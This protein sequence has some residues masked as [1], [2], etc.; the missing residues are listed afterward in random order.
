M[1]ELLTKCKILFIFL[2]LTSFSACDKPTYPTGKIEESIL[3]LCKDEYNLDNVKVKI[4]GSTLGVY[5]PVEGLVDP[6]MQLDKKAGEKIEDVALS[7]HRVVTSTDMPLKFYI[8]TARDTKTAGAEFILTGF[9]YDVVRV[10]LFDI[11]RGEY[12]QRILRDFRFNPAIAGER[13]IRELFDALNQDSPLTESLKPIL[14]PIYAIGKKDTQKIEITDIESKELSDH[15][16]LLYVKTVE[17]YEP[18]PGFEAYGVIFPQGFKNE[19]LFLIDMSSASQIKEIVSRYFYSNNEVR[20]RELKDTFEQYKDLGIIGIDGF[21]KKDLDLGWFLSQQIS[22]RVKQLF[23]EDEKLKKNFKVASSEGEIKDQVFQFKFNIT[24]S[25][26][27]AGD[28]RTIFPNIIKMVGT[29]LHLYEFEEYK[30]VELISL[31]NASKKIY[32]SKEKLE[33]FRKNKIK[34]ESLL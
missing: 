29:V 17:A 22:R 9:I 3:K 20:Q 7:I 27:K 30:G 16:S 24:S 34:I 14:Y 11:S 15:E 31:A 4:V 21:P 32:L 1:K 13:K 5:I 18:S 12:F 19:Y 26:G 23:E 25:D 28:V 10:R 33:I 6:K 8:L 2:I